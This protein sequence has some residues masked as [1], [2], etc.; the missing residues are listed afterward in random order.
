MKLLKLKIFPF[1]SILFLFFLL[2]CMSPS[3]EKALKEIV[4]AE[5]PIS[6]Q[7]SSK[8][9]LQEDVAHAVYINNKMLTAKQRRELTAVYGVPPRPGRYWYDSASGSYGIWHGLSLGVILAGHDFGKI[10]EDASDG[11]TG[12]FIN[13]RELPEA[14]VLFL[15]W[16]FNVPRQPGRYWQDA[17]GN[18]GYEGDPTPL[19]N[20]Y[21]VYQQRI[22]SRF[23]GSGDNYWAGNFGSY[24]NEENG[25]GYV[26][27]DGVSVTYGG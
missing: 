3:Q 4:T 6:G 2:S 26:M 23:Y 14:D 10:P 22:Q 18:I 25:F 20:L 8:A 15:E 24:G 12:V 17:L 11:N 7:P 21:A 27:V 13:D 9:A 19:V 5:E 16:V 1:S